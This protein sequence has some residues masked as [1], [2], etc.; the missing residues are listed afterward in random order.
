MNRAPPMAGPKAANKS[1]MPIMG[2]KKGRPLTAFPWRYGRGA[3]IS[4]VVVAV[5][6]G[7]GSARNAWER[8]TIR[9]RDHHHAVTVVDERDLLAG[10]PSQAFANR[11]R[12]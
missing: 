12:N 8:L 6:I 1:T 10:P 3:S 9:Y 7:I 2:I 11:L 5:T 4:I